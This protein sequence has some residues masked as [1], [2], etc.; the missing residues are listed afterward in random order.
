[1]AYQYAK[2]VIYFRNGKTKVEDRSN[3]YSW[4]GA[5]KYEFYCQECGS[6]YPYFPEVGNMEFCIKCAHENKDSRLVRESSIIAMGISFDPQP[7]EE[8]GE[9]VFSKQ[10]RPLRVKFQPFVMKGSNLYNYGWIQDKPAEQQFVGG[11]K[12]QT[13]GIRIGRVLN[14][15]GHVECLVGYLAQ[16]T[17][18]IYS[19]HTTLHSLG[20]D[21]DAK[22]LHSLKLSECGKRFVKRKEAIKPHI[23]TN[24]GERVEV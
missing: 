17:P 21:K 8:D 19:Y 6:S 12:K 4:D 15:Q 1:M 20:I 7:L 11:S 14:P 22:R 5:P 24:L 2:F 16:G 9:P 18:T 3:P 10:G 23:N 13:F